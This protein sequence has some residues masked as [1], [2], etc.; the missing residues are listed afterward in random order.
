MLRQ[1]QP[2]IANHVPYN[3]KIAC[4][5]KASLDQAEHLSQRP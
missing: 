2:S 4:F 3:A 5:H 1:P